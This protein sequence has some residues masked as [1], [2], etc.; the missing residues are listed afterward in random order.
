MVARPDRG[1]IAARSGPDAL[2]QR[3]RDRILARL[4][5]HDEFAVEAL[6]TLGPDLDDRAEA[7]LRAVPGGYL[8]PAVELAGPTIALTANQPGLLVTLADSYYLMDLGEGADMLGFRGGIRPHHAAGGAPLAAWWYGPF[9]QLLWVRSADALALINHLLD[10]AAT[11]R[12]GA[13]PPPGNDTPGLDLDLPGAGIR[14]CAGDRETWRWYRGGTTAPPPCVSALLA[15]ER[16]ADH[17]LDVVQ[18]P[19]S[20]V[21]ELMLRDCRNLAM[22]GLAVGL[23][24]RHPELAG[25]QLDRWLARPELW[26]LEADRSVGEGPGTLHIQGPDPADLHGR[27]FRGLEMGD[28]AA[29]MTVQAALDGDHDRLAVL[30]A[31]GDELVRRAA[32]LAAGR[33]DAEQQVAIAGRWAAMLRPENYQPVESEDGITFVFQSPSDVAQDLA[34]SHERLE[35]SMTALRLQTTYT[36]PT[37]WDAP[38]DTLITDLTAARQFADDPPPGPVHP[39]DAIAAVAAAAIAAHARNRAEVP[40][41]DLRWAAGVLAE[42]AAHPWAEARITPESR[43]RMGADRSAAAALPALLLPEFNHIRPGMNALEEALA[44][45]GDSIP[46]EVRMIFAQ[47][48]APV[49]T[50]PCGPG[51]TACRHQV[52]WSAVLRGLRDC[53][54]GAWDQVGQRRLIEPLAEPYDQALP[55]VQTERLLVNRLTSPLIAAAD[56]ARSGSCVAQE[57]SRILD[58]LL[59]AHRRGAVRWAEKNYGPPS[60]D[61]HGPAIARVLAEMA[62]AGS[63]QPLAGHIRAFT[64]QSPHALAELLHDLAITFTYHDALRQALPAAWRPVMETALDEMESTS[65]LPADRHWSARALA[66][67]IPAP[68]PDLADADPDTSIEDARKPGRPRTPSAS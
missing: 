60:G 15:V 51:G 29:E 42:V 20:A 35:R 65:D 34:D 4:E 32:D 37:V 58:V 2:R 40:D 64:R 21:I 46:D 18:V 66:G 5:P 61:E 16:W 43:Y 49:W 17:L 54:L 52:L 56:A 28:V 23:L 3:V 48:A 36:S 7:S 53:Q 27:E 11:I 10:H 9:F 55:R 45:C 22:P 30:A 31:I 38:T 8:E 1:L 63:T 33:D 41:V 47:A 6:A 50:A 44:R 67:L 25:S 62:A 14:R 26:R 13:V 57:A 24:V 68:E 19:I 39:A 12:A 59:T